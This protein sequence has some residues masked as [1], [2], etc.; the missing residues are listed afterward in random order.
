MQLAPI[1]KWLK[2]NWFIITIVLLSSGIRFW[3]Y[4]RTPYAPGWDSYF[5]IVQI[6]SYIEE[7]VMHSSRLSL[8][9]PILLLIQLI[10]N[11]YELTY[12]IT[13]ALLVGSFTLQMFLTAK[14]LNKSTNLAY[15]VASYTLFSPQ[16]TYFASQYSKNLLGVIFLLWMIQATINKRYIGAS[17]L[18]L[19]NF[20]I[21][22]LTAGLSVFFVLLKIASSKINKKVII[23]TTLT[24]LI[25]ILTLWA[26][27]IILDLKDFHREGFGLSSKFNWPS[28][29]FI[30]DFKGL[31]DFPWMLDIILS[32]VCFAGG[33]VLILTRPKN[34]SNWIPVIFILTGL[35][36]PF[37]E[38]S[39]LGISFRALMLFLI[40]CPL[41]IATIDLHRLVSLIMSSVLILGALIFNKSY[42]QSK[43]DPPYG[44]YKT[45]SNK[46]LEYNEIQFELII[47]HKALAEYVTFQTGIDAM[48]W[49][50][51]Y[52]IDNDKLW[53]ICTGLN[54]KTAKYYGQ[55]DF[56]ENYY[57]ELTPN[58]SLIREGLWDSAINNM[59]Q[60]EPEYLESLLTWK[61]PNQKRPSYM[62]KYKVKD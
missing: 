44:T 20:F 18:L 55:K 14:A 11:N 35:T 59:S 33:T 61:N 17:L 5:Y 42:D 2:S 19:S 31:L 9:Y 58:Y 13:S 46:I 21:H 28:Y 54:K 34:K 23:T 60:E 32:N 47:A 15:L 40:L 48:P 7:G 36:L 51:E 30:K 56:K 3:I 62:T 25:L 38:W 10:V 29:R 41:L 50:P 1:T 53:R 16:L 43:H 24:G 8:F 52:E 4:N 39:L 57:Y 22:K 27:P 37:L 45:I 26:I 12:K 49:E 6:K